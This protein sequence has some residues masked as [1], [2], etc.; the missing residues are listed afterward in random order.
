[1]KKK[2]KRRSRPKSFADTLRA[3]VQNSGLTQYRIAK[4]GGCSTQDPVAR[5]MSG[6]DSRLSTVEMIAKGMGYR[7]VLE[8]LE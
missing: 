8:P 7:I 5:F 3:A 2:A 6:M 1:M 4:D